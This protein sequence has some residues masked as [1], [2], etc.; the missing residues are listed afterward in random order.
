[1]F[2]S[3]PLSQL[4]LQAHVHL[5]LLLD[6]SV[7]VHRMCCCCMRTHSGKENHVMALPMRCPGKGCAF[8]QVSG[9]QK[10]LRHV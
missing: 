8:R 6:A 5:D 3:H 9:Q 1:M 4:I 2:L 10:V 7:Y